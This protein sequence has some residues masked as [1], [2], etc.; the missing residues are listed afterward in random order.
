MINRLFISRIGRRGVIVKINR[1][2][3]ILRHVPE[4][5][6]VV[7]GKNRSVCSVVVIV[8]EVK[9][10]QDQV[11]SEHERLSIT[12]RRFRITF[13]S[14]R[15]EVTCFAYISSFAIRILVISPWYFICF[16]II[17]KDTL[18]TSE[19]ESGRNQVPVSPRLFV[20]YSDGP[21]SLPSVSF[22]VSSNCVCKIS[23]V[24][25]LNPVRPVC[26]W[27]DSLSVC[28]DVPVWVCLESHW[29]LGVAGCV[30]S[31]WRDCSCCVVICDLGSIRVTWSVSNPI[32]QTITCTSFFLTVKGKIV[33]NLYSVAIRSY[34]F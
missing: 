13:N 28:F 9:W 5:W 6:N 14:Q 12:W 32:R 22:Q 21:L 20:C 23:N 10:G 31:S 26:E 33:K 19:L 1:P 25:R 24:I 8:D 7:R 4:G 3:A 27:P 2:I 29:V 15:H 17:F 34:D 11:L 18:V 16:D 30:V